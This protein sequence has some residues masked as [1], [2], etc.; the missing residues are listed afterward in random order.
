[1]ESENQ[2][3]MD[4]PLFFG[5]KQ[6]QQDGEK[7]L[8]NNRAKALVTCHIKLLACLLLLCCCCLG[9]F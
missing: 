2:K 9:V 8:K 4:E 1:M 5:T 3:L 6:T 7:V